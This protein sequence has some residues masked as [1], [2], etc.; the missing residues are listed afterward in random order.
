MVTDLSA[1]HRAATRLIEQATFGDMLMVE[2]FL[3]GEEVTVTV[4]PPASPRPD[5]TVGGRH[6]P[7]RPVCRF[8][9]QDGVAPYN[10]DVP[11]TANSKAMSVDRL[12]DPAVAA[13]IKDCCAAA[14]YVG[15]RAAI[16]IDCRRDHTGTFKLFDLNMKPNM[17]GP[18]RP[19]RADQQSLSAIAARAEGWSYTDLLLA[20]LASSWT[21]A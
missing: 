16:R 10:G 21:A 13:M 20:M 5:G 8:G 3:D 19:G 9:Q 2:E 11:V 4:M 7:L 1:L 15:A 18:G 14:E 17:T 6:W 12:A